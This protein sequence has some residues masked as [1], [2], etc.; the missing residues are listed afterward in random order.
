[1]PPP[2]REVMATLVTATDHGDIFTFHGPAM[3]STCIPVNQAQQPLFTVASLHS[4]QLAG[5]RLAMV[6]NSDA[7]VQ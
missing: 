1:M 7:S 5:Y 4:G 3:V 2:I 6:A